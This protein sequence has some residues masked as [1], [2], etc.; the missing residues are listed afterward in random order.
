MV[1]LMAIKIKSTADFSADTGV[2]IV[3]YGQ[4]GIGKTRL[5]LKAADSI[6]LSA[7]RGLLSLKN[8]NH[9]YIEI[10]SP[11]KVDEAYEWLK[12]DKQF[13]TV[14]LDTVSEVGEVL[15]T[16]FLLNG[17]GIIDGP[18]KDAR[19]GYRMMAEAMMPMIRKFRDIPDK[20]IV[21]NAKLGMKE[22]KEG[23]LM[24]RHA[25]IPGRVIPMQIPYMFDCVFYFH[26]KKNQQR[27]DVPVFQT[28]L[29]SDTI[30]KDRSGT[31]AKFEPPDIDAIIRKIK[32]K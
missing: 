1:I 11:K 4:S 13:K 9:P 25:M 31:L 17:N 29:S 26:L 30:A 15:L 32:A 2:K 3:V 7:E 6:I 12:R 8:E 10:G 16:D 14:F 18:L 24:Y 20:N 5:A 28:Y 19:Q 27:E 22:D 21:F 23:D